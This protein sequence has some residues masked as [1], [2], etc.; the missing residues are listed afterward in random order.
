LSGT[1]LWFCHCEGRNQLF[2]ESAKLLRNG[3]AFFESHSEQ[4]F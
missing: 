4:A 3:I 1:L 2:D